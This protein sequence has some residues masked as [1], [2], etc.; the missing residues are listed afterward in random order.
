MEDTALPEQMLEVTLHWFHQ[1][2][3]HPGMYR[4][5]Y[6]LQQRYHHNLLRRTIDRHRCEYC[7]KDTLPGK[8]YGF[9]P[10]REIEIAPWE[11]VAID[12]IGPWKVQVH[13]K[14]MSSML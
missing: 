10:E 7:L 9:L 4:L 6:T 3:G 8:C 13:E 11:E 12:L 14:M 2:I 1:V 5:R